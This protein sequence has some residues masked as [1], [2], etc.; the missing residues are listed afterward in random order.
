MSNDI[1]FVICDALVGEPRMPF[2]DFTP[3]VAD[4]RSEMQRLNFTSAIVRHRASVEIAGYFGNEL[5]MDQIA[6][7]AK[8]LPAWFVT[9]DGQEPEFD[10]KQLLDEMQAKGARLAW[11]DPQFEGFSLHPGYSGKLLAALQD[12]KIPL[13]LSYQKVDWDHLYLVLQDFPDLPIILLEV[14][15]LGRN[16]MI[17]PLLERFS[18]LYL[19]LSSSFSVHKGF[20]DLCDRYGSSRWVFG[21]NYPTY[22]SGA[23]VTSLMYAGL[24]TEEIE[25]IAHGNIERLLTE[26]KS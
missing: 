21:S 23:A 3:T 17:E 1:S 8:L 2:P 15:R 19:C 7:D 11:T 6:G 10:V 14:P 12:R 13:L 9:P 20:R 16:R 4:L 26:V 24:T 18:Q 25:A 22:E 5:L